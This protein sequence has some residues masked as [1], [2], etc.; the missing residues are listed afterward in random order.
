M[1]PVWDKSQREDRTYSRDDFRH[2]EA[3]DVNQAAREDTRAL[4]ATDVH[5][6]SRRKKIEA[7]FAEAKRYL[8]P[9]RLRRRGPTPGA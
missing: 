6:R 9:T 5:S 1:I 2:D 7:L 8:A 3:R 4:M